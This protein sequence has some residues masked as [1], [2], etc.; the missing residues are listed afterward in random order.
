MLSRRTFGL[1]AAA[2]VVLVLVILA[3]SL[4]QLLAT[5]AAPTALPTRTPR[6]TWTGVVNDFVEASA[7]LDLAQGGDTG[8]ML[9]QVALLPS[10]AAQATPQPPLA[11]PMLVVG[12][13]QQPITVPLS[14]G[15]QNAVVTIVVVL[16]TATPPA[17]TSTVVTST[18]PVTGSLPASAPE[19]QATPVPSPSVTSPSP[20][21]SP[22]GAGR[23][24]VRAP[25]PC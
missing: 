21:G 25:G 18:L 2:F 10:T 23:W 1:L 12:G 22:R 13:T 7:T 9:P 17:P 19:M 20:G 4:G 16:V 11:P 15:S 24:H 6:P 5:R 3:C 14:S 8:G